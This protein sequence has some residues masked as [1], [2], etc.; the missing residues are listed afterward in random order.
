MPSYK[1][2]L[3]SL[4]L[5]ALAHGRT[6]AR[7]QPV[8]ARE[9]PS[10]RDTT[11]FITSTAEITTLDATTGSSAVVILDYG[12]SVEGIPAFDV[13]SV[14][15]DTS[16]FEITYGESKAALDSYM[17]DGPLPLAAAMDT[18]RVNRYNISGPGK[19]SNRLVQG[20]FRY[21]KL[22]LSSPGVLSVRNV[23]A[24][25]TIHTTALTELPGFFESSD[26]TINDIWSVGARTIQMTE[27]P[28]DTVPDFWEVTPEG[29][30]VDSL[31]PQSLGSA[32]AAQSL[33]YSLQFSVKPVVGGF[34]FTV[35]ADTLSSG[36][37]FS[38]D[39]SSGK[40]TAHAGSTSE[41][42][43][44]QAFDLPKNI[45]LA[46]GS[47]STVTATVAV[48]DISVSI[49]G[50]QVVQMSQTTRFFGSFG[51]GASFGH[52]AIFKDL[53]AVSAEG[54]EIYSHPLTD[55]S[56]LADFF[57]GTNPASTI[58]DGSRRD[59]IAYTGDLDVAG[60]AA[61]VSTHGLE[62]IIGSLDLLGS[63]QTTPGFFIPTAKIQQ[64]PLSQELNINVTGLIG[65]SFNF[66]TAVASTYLHTGDVGFAQKWA[67][68]VQK[69]LDW[70]DSQTL[71]NGLFNVS[72]AS[73]AGDWNYYDPAQ[74]GVST[75]FNVLYAY[76]L[77]ESL[78]LLADGGVDAK[79]YQE[80]LD[81]LRDA[82]DS[83]LWSDDLQA[84]YFSADYTNGF[85]QDSNAIA[86]L[87]GVN[88]NPAHSSEII[89]STL[90]KDLG[91]PA[92]PMAFS[93]G[94]I[95]SGFQPYISPYASAYHLRA[96][97]ASGN[98]DASLELLRSLW[99]P[100]AD[101]NNANYTGSFWETLNEEGRPGLGLSTSLCHG[102]AAG[103]TAEL[104]KYVLGVMPT[105]P[106]WSEFSV[107]PLTLGLKSAKG[108]VPLVEGQ[109]NVEW[110][111]SCGG[112][113]TM[114]VEAPTGTK[115]TVTLPRPLVT[116][117]DD[118]VFTVNGQAVNATT[119]EVVGG[120]TFNLQQHHKV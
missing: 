71:E 115:G 47:W 57:M 23:G 64:A 54:Q 61:L 21:Q 76:S 3:P 1:S 103:P 48:T 111:F 36:I 77:Q 37:Y 100:M 13:V 11:E 63:Y 32:A 78:T 91:R 93:S 16:T 40:I 95:A 101:T 109:V 112:L 96:A 116:S 82:I 105:H 69:M 4:A 26:K 60:G 56:F 90:S 27:I 108:R 49:N 87:A 58:V 94:I 19:V 83:Q 5:L 8:A 7:V 97:L 45:T 98:S 17:S 43:L 110:K 10:S 25:P 81:S 66:V 18:F 30:L 55:S 59:R 92:G 80:R 99:A 33:M 41:N 114:V 46:L 75:K 6:V 68:K 20:A 2:L 15:G 35:L 39:I 38:C 67:P 113:L 14:E 51:L 106:G 44:L 86:I 72:E 118:S 22:N 84:Y 88:K 74:P 50:V 53:S 79:I 62:Y 12:W 85:G 42:P 52:R 107:A 73:F 119:F 29:A 28:A 70:A 104:T 120:S 117:I 102:W 9:P 24:R 31:A 89:L 34:G 65:Y